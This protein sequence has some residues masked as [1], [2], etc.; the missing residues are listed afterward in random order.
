MLI[1]VGDQVPKDGEPAEAGRFLLWELPLR[2][3]PPGCLDPVVLV[4][5]SAWSE[6]V[7][8]I[9]GPCLMNRYLNKYIAY[10]PSNYKKLRYY[11][12]L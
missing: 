6:L 5:R 9:G 2:L 11:S 10:L 4:S 8:D 3:H 1:G 7:R 12:H